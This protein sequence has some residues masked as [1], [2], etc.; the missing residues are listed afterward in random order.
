MMLQ[1][2]K[3]IR[4]LR[5]QQKLTQ[6]VLAE[7]IVSEAVMSRIENGL[8]EPGLFTLNELFARLGKSLA[9]FELIVSNQDFEQLKRGEYKA[10]LQTV[11][12]AESEYFKDLRGAKGMSQEQ[13]SSEIFARE[14]ISKIEHGRTPQNKK[15]QSLMAKLEEPFERYYG[16]VIALEYEVYEWVEEYQKVFNEH[17]E[18][19]G[20]IRRRIKEKINADCPVN[21]QFLESS[22][23]ME[24]RQMGMITSGEALA[25]LEKCLRYTMPEYDG[26]IYR[27][28]YRQEAIILEEIVKC[29]KEVK[30]M[31]AAEQLLK[32]IAKKNEKKLKLS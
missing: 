32:K 8:V 27:I 19:A 18:R 15:L 29:L 31:A 12:V 21:R 24:Q 26:E 16:Y 10:S 2:G 22:E 25:G 1:I 5:K 9:P 28:P 7:G 6:K 14:T 17:P 3:I 20:E 13:F 4:Q 30:R 23:L 11:V